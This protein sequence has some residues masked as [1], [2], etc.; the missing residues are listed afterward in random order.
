MSDS[1]GFSEYLDDVIGG[2]G[3]WDGETVVVPKNLCVATLSLL[4]HLMEELDPS[5]LP[6]SLTAAVVRLNNA[7][8]AVVEGGAS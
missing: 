7:I 3:Y 1:T 6:Q 2:E 8:G 5:P 4:Q